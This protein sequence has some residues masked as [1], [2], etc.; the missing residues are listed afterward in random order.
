MFVFKETSI[1]RLHCAWRSLSKKPCM[2]G[3]SLVRQGE[4]VLLW[5]SFFAWCPMEEVLKGQANLMPRTDF[6]IVFFQA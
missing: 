5:L 2:L 6:I 3:V 4:M 1:R